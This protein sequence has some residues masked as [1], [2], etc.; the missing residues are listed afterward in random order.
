MTA[1]GQTISE[2]YTFPYQTHPIQ[3]IQLVATS[4][5]TSAVNFAVSGPQSPLAM[6]ASL[7]SRNIDAGSSSIFSPA[8]QVGAGDSQAVTDIEDAPASSTARDVV[9]LP[10]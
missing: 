4:H 2:S 6:Q 7:P 3:P 5:D 8:G 9:E 10:P 1:L